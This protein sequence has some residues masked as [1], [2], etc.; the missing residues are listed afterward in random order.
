MRLRWRG[1]IC[2]CS[3]VAVGTA[4]LGW[5]APAQEPQ[6]WAHYVRIGA[7][8]LRPDNAEKIVNDAIMGHV[9]GIEVDNDIPG[10]YE[11]LVEPIVKLKA[12]HDVAEAAHKAN[13]QAFMY[14]AGRS[15]SPRTATR[16][17][18]L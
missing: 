2:V 16:F 4:C 11:S 8:S 17:R 12:I 14:I 18:I 9:F 10:R 6:N 15:A 1:A 13:N 3:V 5:R 7:Y